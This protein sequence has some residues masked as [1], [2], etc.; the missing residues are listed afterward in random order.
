[1]PCQ[2]FFSC[3][4]PHV[5]ALRAVGVED[6]ARGGHHQTARL[7]PR[8]PRT[9]PHHSHCYLSFSHTPLSLRPEA[10]DLPFRGPSKLTVASIANR[11]AV[12]TLP[13]ILH[14]LLQQMS[15]WGW[16]RLSR[17]AVIAQGPPTSAQVAK[18]HQG[19]LSASM[20]VATK[21][22]RELS[23]SSDIS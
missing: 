13:S 20:S 17:S 7:R 16:R 3:K 2:R 11:Q 1:M 6:Q 9:L 21:F 18:E 23:T 14:E 5:R 15:T 22:T 4:N 8:D 19:D 10:C 12:R